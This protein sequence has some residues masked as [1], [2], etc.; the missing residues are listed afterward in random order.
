M[1]QLVFLN[2]SS[3]MSPEKYCTNLSHSLWPNQ[4]IFT[5]SEILPY[6]GSPAEYAKPNVAMSV[7]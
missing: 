6:G 1:K 2:I 5:I 4:S 3:T 7:R